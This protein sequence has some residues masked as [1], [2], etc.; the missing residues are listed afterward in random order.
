MIG[1]LC[2]RVEEIPLCPSA[3]FDWVHR[4]ENCDWEYWERRVW[5]RLY[6][7]YI[8]V[9]WVCRR[10]GCRVSLRVWQPSRKLSFR[11]LKVRCG[12]F[13][14][15]KFC[16]T[17]RILGQV[18]LATEGPYCSG[19]SGVLRCSN[20]RFGTFPMQ[21]GYP[22]ICSG[23]VRRWQAVF[24]PCCEG[25]TSQRLGL[26]LLCSASPSICQ[27]LAGDFGFSRSAPSRL[28]K[29]DPF[30]SPV[31]ASLVLVCSAVP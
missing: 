29:K 1:T 21:V 22:L 25:Q 11:S 13:C 31:S 16:W 19:H 18:L 15:R 14:S 23:C 17:R 30:P 28:R 24:F 5:S 4:R 27:L 26:F 6:T 7:N 2:R 12:F 20:R 8:S 9:S 3:I 10:W